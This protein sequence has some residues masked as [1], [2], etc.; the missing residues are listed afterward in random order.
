MSKKAW[1]AL[2]VWL[3]VLAVVAASLV[4]YSNY[5]AAHVT[6]PGATV[7]SA[8]YSVGTEFSGV[9][10]Q[11]FVQTGAAVTAGE[12]LF[13]LKSSDLTAELENGQI[14]TADLTSSLTSDGQL[15]ISAAKAG[16][17]QQVDYSFGSF[18]P[19]D[20][21]VATLTDSSSL[22]VDGVFKMT[23]HQFGEVNDTTPM[24]VTL[25]NGS[26]L[27]TNVSE[28]NILQ[29]GAILSVDIS[30]TINNSTAY[31]QLQAGNSSP[32]KATLQLN[33]ATLWHSLNNWYH[34]EYRRL[35]NL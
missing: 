22:Q 27:T 9:I 34:R 31:D 20:K 15:I 17:V 35:K 12:P 5:S 26:K 16:R 18:V 6:A 28:I 1:R 8:T 24:Q 14:T 23:A 10:T 19:A 2:I 32:A 3:I 13:Y 30:A 29:Q 33:N 4:I 11:Q 25:A 7:Q 21:E